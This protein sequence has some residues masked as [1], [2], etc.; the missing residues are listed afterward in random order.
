MWEKCESCQRADMTF[1]KVNADPDI[2][3]EGI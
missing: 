1:E 2:E 3:E